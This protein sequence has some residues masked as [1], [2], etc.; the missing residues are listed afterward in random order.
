MAADKAG[1]SAGVGSLLVFVYNIVGVMRVA[2]Y[3]C[4]CVCVCMY[5]TAGTALPTVYIKTC[6]D[7]SQS[8]QPHGYRDML[9]QHH[10]PD[11]A[12]PSRYDQSQPRQVAQDHG[13]SY[14]ASLLMSQ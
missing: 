4:V 14:H 1:S 10:V 8:M 13:H 5:S 7:Y 6:L 11:D 2:C 3:V 12:I 9:K